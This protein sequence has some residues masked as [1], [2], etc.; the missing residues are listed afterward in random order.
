MEGTLYFQ[1]IHRR[2][3]RTVCTGCRVT[4]RE[5]DGAS[6][7]I[8]IVGSPARQASLRLAASRMRSEAR[9]I[10]AIIS[11]KEPVGDGIRR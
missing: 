9:R 8:R 2:V 6:S 10:A 11:E 3:V 5:W 7:S 1:I 4:A